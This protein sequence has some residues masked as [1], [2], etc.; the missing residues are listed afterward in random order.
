MTPVECVSLKVDPPH[1]HG[2]TVAE[3]MGN[4]RKT[5]AIPGRI[6]GES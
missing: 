3:G 5:V 4:R 2:D 1:R 6:L